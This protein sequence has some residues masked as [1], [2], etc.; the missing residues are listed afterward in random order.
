MDVEMGSRAVT[1]GP[2][3]K[4]CYAC[5]TELEVTATSCS[6]CQA[7]QPRLARGSMGTMGTSPI[8]VPRAPAPVVH[9]KRKRTAA[10][11]ALFLG[12]VGAHKL[13]LRQ[14]GAAVVYL[15][16]CWSLAPAILGI[17]DFIGLLAMTEAELDRE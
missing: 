14:R 11:L 17:V 4:Q 7:R 13:Y 8:A 10:L 15:L 5:A 16:F 12:G 2:A 6:V 3:R 9:T 1:Q